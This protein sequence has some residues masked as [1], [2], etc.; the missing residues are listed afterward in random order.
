MGTL[1]L[2]IVVGLLFVGHG[3]QKL[4]GLFGGGGIQQT[5]KTMDAIG[6]HPANVQA[7]AAALAETAGG[8]ALAL[9]AATP[10]A[11]AGLV[12][13]MLTAIRKVHGKNGLWNSKGGYEF[14]LVMIAAATLLAERPGRAS[15]DGALG[16]SRWGTGWAIFA[17]VGGAIG[18]VLAV[19]AGKRFAP[20]VEPDQTGATGAEGPEATEPLPGGAEG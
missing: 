15:I 20:S 3:L 7:R 17:L 5:E 9:G 16:R 19:E 11:S 12:A 4:G 6:M 13:T 10:F 18:S 2:R 14:N 8:A 1:I